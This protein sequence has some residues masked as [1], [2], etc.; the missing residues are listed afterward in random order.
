MLLFFG[1]GY[2]I[3]TIGILGLGF[4][5]Y[6]YESSQE[7]HFSNG[8]IY[9]EYPLGNAISDYRGKRVKI[10]R[11][12]KWLPFEWLIYK[13][14]YRGFSIA[15]KDLNVDFINTENSL[16]L[17]TNLEKGDSIYQWADTIILDKNN[18]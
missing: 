16:I 12:S 17:S 8:I 7:K 3:S 2:F 10:L 1:I 4:I 11:T 14:E 15:G 5:T 13:T 9:K 18:H 6:E